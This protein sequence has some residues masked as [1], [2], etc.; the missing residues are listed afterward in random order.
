M[1][2]RKIAAGAVVFGCVAL[3]GAPLGLLWWLIAP[4]GQVTVT[5]GGTTVFY[6]LSE[7]VFAGEG[8]YALMMLV[9]GLLTG[10][11][12]YLAQ[13]SSTRR[14]GVDLRMPTLLGISAGALAGAV[15]AWVVGV[16]LDVFSAS[17]AQSF[18]A[19]GDVVEQGLSLRSHSAL[20]LWPF[21]AILQYGLFDAVSLWRGDLPTAE[22]ARTDTV[23]PVHDEADN[24]RGPAPVER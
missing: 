9:A 19:P 8:Y 21:V 17:G 1:T 13:Y 24:S 3:L 18:A 14:H 15:L 6:P 22:D 10:Y 4:R 11:L 16:G 20:L 2:E 23:E 7:T 5:T 12:A